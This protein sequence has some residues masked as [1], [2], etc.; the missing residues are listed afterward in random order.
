MVRSTRNYDNSGRKRAAEETRAA[1]L[2]AARTILL[3]GGYD[4]M[5]I[6]SLARAAGVSPQTIYNSVGDKA[7]VVKACYDVV[8]AGDAEPVPMSERPAFRA[9]S[10]ATD[11]PAF[12]RAYAHWC[13]DINSRVG[14]LLGRLLTAG[15]RDESLRSFLRAIDQER[16]LGT[17]HAMT[18]LQRAHGLPDAVPLERAIDVA[19]TLNSPEVYE[20]LVTRC[21]WPLDDYEH[22]LANQLAAVLR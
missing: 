10:L 8:L 17:T 13:R 2:D 18:A 7:A 20:R 22:W 16:R 19:W 21:G 5:T 14:G 9:L 1:I 3:E 6:A 12:L 15:G 4:E 11:R